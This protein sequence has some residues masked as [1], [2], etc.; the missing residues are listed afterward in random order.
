MSSLPERLLPTEIE[1]RLT[2]RWLGRTLYC[3]EEVSSTNDIARELARAGAAEGTV[4]IA[5]SQTRGRGRLGRSWESPK[6]RNLYLSAVLRPAMAGTTLPR[7]SL[8]AGVAVCDAICEWYPAS[9]KWPNDILIEGRKV[10]G[11]LAEIEP[12]AAVILGIGVNLNSA[13]DEF[14]PELRDKAGSLFVATGVRVDRPVFVT[15][16]LAHLEA[17]YDQHRRD[18]FAPIA[19][20]WGERSL[21]IGKTISVEEPG[22]EVRGEVLGID[23]D[24]ALRLR[25]PSGTVHRVIAGDVTVVGGYQLNESTDSGRKC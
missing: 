23:T 12:P 9:I 2:T 18:G 22:G 10:A 16:L 8:V 17:R 19:D 13:L 7:L 24:G 6:H 5:E 14:P 15:R 21:M 1:G 3:H 4:V 11:L 20:A 25:L